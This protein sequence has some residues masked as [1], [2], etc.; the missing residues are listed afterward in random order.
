M[1]KSTLIN[2][3]VGEERVIVSDIPGTTRD[4]I[5]TDFTY[6]GQEFVLIDTAGMRRKKKIDS[7]VEHYS[8]LRALRAIDRSDIVFLMLDAHERVT[9]Q[10]QRIAGYIH[11]NGKGCAIVVNKWDLVEKETN[12]MRD[13]EQE[14]LSKLQFL[15]YAPVEFISAHRKTGSKLLDQAISIAQQKLAHFHR[16]INEIIKMLFHAS[17]SFRQRCTAKVLYAPKFKSIHLCS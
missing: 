5:D 11:E 13:Y 8:V 12:T 17:A 9:E 15:S 16:K 7:G 2:Q 10:D 3:F 6:D 4:A 14:I 1:G